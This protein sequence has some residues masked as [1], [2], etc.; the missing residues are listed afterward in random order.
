MGLPFIVLAS[1]RRNS[2]LGEK[3]KNP[4][5]CL[6]NA[7]HFSCSQCITVP[8]INSARWTSLCIQISSYRWNFQIQVYKHVFKIFD[9]H[10]Q[11]GFINLYSYQHSFI[12]SFIPSLNASS[13][14]GAVLGPR[15]TWPTRQGASHSPRWNSQSGGR[16][17]GR[18]TLLFRGVYCILKGCIDSKW[19]PTFLARNQLFSVICLLSLEKEMLE[20]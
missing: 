6:T 7:G 5:S 2:D 15:D 12:C 13:V 1:L 19:L 17:T 4:V 20:S 11:Q 14:W 9:S 10:Y 18:G 8:R 16:R 3:I